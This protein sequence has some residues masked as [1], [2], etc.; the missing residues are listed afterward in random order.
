MTV[1]TNEPAGAL[2]IREAA[3]RTEVLLADLAPAAVLPGNNPFT[4]TLEFMSFRALDLVAVTV[5]FFEYLG[6]HFRAL[7]IL[8]TIFLFPYEVELGNIFSIYRKL[9]YAGPRVNRNI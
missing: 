2:V 9:Y 4:H 1:N 7:I 8:L 3:I 5:G 6:Y